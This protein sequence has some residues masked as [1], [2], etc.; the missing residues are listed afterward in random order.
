MGYRADIVNPGG[1]PLTA[2]ADEAITAGYALKLVAVTGT[3]TYR[4]GIADTAASDIIVGI[5]V[6][7]AAA[8]EDVFAWQPIGIVCRGVAGDTV[9]LGAALTCESGGRLIA[10]TTV[11]DYA[12]GLALEASTDGND[13]SFLVGGHF[14]YAATS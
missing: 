10:T 2:T 6:E 13:F 11:G 1:G 3:E 9:T 4:L 12:I 8:A 7:D 14:R 5:A